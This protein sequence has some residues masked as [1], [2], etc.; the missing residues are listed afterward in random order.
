MSFL[1][2]QKN[3]KLSQTQTNR[4]TSKQQTSQ[5]FSQLKIGKQL[6]TLKTEIDTI[7]KKTD[8]IEPA[9]DQIQQIKAYLFDLIDQMN[10]PPTGQ[11]QEDPIKMLQEQ[12][13]KISENQ[14]GQTEAIERVANETASLTEAFNSMI[15][16][17]QNAA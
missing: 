8:D 10:A 5:K 11:D 13:E 9:F 7:S 16:T 4:S 15:E 2:K 17:L 3:E 1:S 14:V 6:H 12:L